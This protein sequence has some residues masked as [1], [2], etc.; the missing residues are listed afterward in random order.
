MQPSA[1][2][3]RHLRSDSHSCSN[4]IQALT[5]PVKPAE[6]ASPIKAVAG[7][8]KP[9]P[10]K[11]GNKE[12]P[13]PEPEL[14]TMPGDPIKILTPELALR[15]NPLVVVPLR[16][17]CI[18]DAP[19]TAAQLD[20]KC[21]PVKLRMCWPAKVCACTE[22][23]VF[24]SLSRCVPR[25]VQAYQAVH[26]LACQGVCMRQS[27]RFCWPVKCVYKCVRAYQA[28]HELLIDSTQMESCH[29]YA[30]TFW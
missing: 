10:A 22:V 16:A 28:V 8:G 13:A 15:L 12:A 17:N 24:A 19:A 9:A 18:P 21:E 6:D 5:A 20:E 2:E 11:G 1:Q 29:I 30:F 26:V 4:T 27:V 23:C 7:K 3:L 14:S 25:C